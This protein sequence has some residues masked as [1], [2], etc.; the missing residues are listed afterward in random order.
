M[1]TLLFAADK[2]S[3]QDNSGIKYEEEMDKRRNPISKERQKVFT[4]NVNDV[5]YAIQ[6]NKN[7]NCGLVFK[8]GLK[9]GC[10]ARWVPI[11]VLQKKQVNE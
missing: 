2:D 4:I 9:T 6:K 8:V 5:N 10:G 1:S 3:E 7:K 11:R